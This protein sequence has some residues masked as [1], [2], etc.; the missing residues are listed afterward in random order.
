[1]YRPLSPH[2]LIYKPQF[3]SVL[4]VLQRITGA[5]PSLGSLFVLFC[6]K[7]ITYHISFHPIHLISFH[8]N[9]Y[10][11]WVIVSIFVVSLFSFFYHSFNGIRHLLWDK[12]YFMGKDDMT[13]SAYSPIFSTLFFS[14]SV[15]FVPSLQPFPVSFPL[16]HLPRGDRCAP[17]SIPPLGLRCPRGGLAE[18]PQLRGR[19]AGPRGTLSSAGRA[20]AF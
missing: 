10:S 3:C 1:M 7:F 16:F 19:Q 14:F 4:S 17:P 5:I 11:P 18:T 12:A 13:A 8:P 20:V 15:P 2:P 9:T 6:L